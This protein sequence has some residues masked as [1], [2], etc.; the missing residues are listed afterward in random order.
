MPKSREGTGS[1][2]AFREEGEAWRILVVQPAGEATAPGVPFAGSRGVVSARN[3]HALQALRRALAAGRPFALAILRAGGLAMAS[4]LAA[5]DP[6]LILVLPQTL[7]GRDLPPSQMNRVFFAEPGTEAETRLL[8]SLLAR[9]S[10]ESRFDEARRLLEASNRALLAANHEFRRQNARLLVQESQLSAQTELFQATLDNMHHGLMLVGADR[11]VRMVNR[12]MHTVSGLAEGVI[13]VGMTSEEVLARS[14]E[15]G[16]YGD[17]GSETVKAQWQERLAAGRAG[18]FQRD[19]ADGRVVTIAYA[20]MRD[21]GWL[22]TCED[23]TARV[24]AERAL[25][26]QNRRFDAAIV[27]MPYGV[28][29]FDE[30]RRMILCNPTYMRMYDL[31][32]EMTLPGTPLA[33]I[34]QYR[35]R[36]GNAPVDLEHYVRITTEL[37]ASGRDA[38]FQVLLADGRTVQIRHNVI[39]GGSYVATHEDV[40][41]ALRRRSAILPATMR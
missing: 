11:R 5:L 3:P 8:R 34:L 23:A 38:A 19:L 1:R 25:A 32:Q 4:R 28:C 37:T 33:E 40:T 18:A 10:A 7:A 27:H 12:R 14:L 15:A 21:G 35:V 16:L 36:L 31:P 17:R 41:D 20:P 2:R 26:E 13:A 22:F 29:L 9:A 6:A 39:A 30:G 24:L